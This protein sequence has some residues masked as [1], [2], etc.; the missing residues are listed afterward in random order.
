MLK[1]IREA[2]TYATLL[3]FAGFVCLIIAAIYWL[4]ND[5][6]ILLGRTLNVESLIL[7]L[8]IIGNFMLS[9]LIRLFPQLEQPIFPN[10]TSRPI[11]ETIRQTNR[12]RMLDLVEQ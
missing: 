12:E 2:L 5:K 7:L 8:T 4:T 6:V 10:T 1:Q 11:A 9:R 3:R